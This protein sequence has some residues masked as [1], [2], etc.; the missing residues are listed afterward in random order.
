MNRP[1]LGRLDPHLSDEEWASRLGLSTDTP[2]E[3]LVWFKPARLSDAERRRLSKLSYA[4]YLQTPLWQQRRE[5]SLALA[6]HHC[7]RCGSRRRLQVH[8]RTYDRLGEEADEDL[9][10]LC[11]ACHRQEHG[12]TEGVV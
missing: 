9:E 1:S 7:Q 10:V 4:E 2:D 3:P 12:I 11:D 6:R 8:H 5:R